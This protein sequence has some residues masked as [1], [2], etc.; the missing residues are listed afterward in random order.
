MNVRKILDAKGREVFAVRPDMPMRAFAQLIGRRKIGAAPVTDGDG[1]MVGIIS[2]RDV[3]RG[4]E[5]HG[6]DL[7]G[8]TVSELMSTNVISCAPESTISD[9]AVL[10]S[11]HGI[12]HIA[13]LDD[14]DALAGF[15]S[16]RDIAFSRLTELELDNEAL[17]LMFDDME[18]VG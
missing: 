3:V 9:V 1:D 4:F 6:A 8:M 10:M 2:E 14:D 17:R 5:I 11:K 16:I 12:R 15:I 18:T 13:V 7:M